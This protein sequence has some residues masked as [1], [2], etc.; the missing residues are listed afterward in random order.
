MEWSAR[1]GTLCTSSTKAAP[2]QASLCTLLFL[3]TSP[4]HLKEWIVSSSVTSSSRKLLQ[5]GSSRGCAD[6]LAKAAEHQL[7]ILKLATRSEVG[8]VVGYPSASGCVLSFS[9]DEDLLAQLVQLG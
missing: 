5:D 2:F 6:H 4:S 9:G 8:N 3:T 7:P 1:L